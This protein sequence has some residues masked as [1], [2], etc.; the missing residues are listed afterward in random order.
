[1]YM[2]EDT[3]LYDLEEGF[4]WLTLSAQNGYSKAKNNVVTCYLMGRGTSQDNQQA[5]YWAKRGFLAIAT[6]FVAISYDG[7]S[8]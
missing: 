2:Q 8:D 5:L 3:A 4:H 7:T 6:I 1:M